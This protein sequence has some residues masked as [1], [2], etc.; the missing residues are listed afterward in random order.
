MNA[1]GARGFYAREH[2][3]LSVCQPH[4]ATRL[5]AQNGEK[6]RELDM[7]CVLN[8]TEDS[9]QVVPP[10]ESE[11]SFSCLAKISERTRRN[12]KVNRRGVIC[13]PNMFIYRKFWSNQFD[14]NSKL[15]CICGREST[16]CLLAAAKI[17]FFDTI[18]DQKPE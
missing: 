15:F 17:I 4:S 7:V 5:F 3:H 1:H 14:Q 13:G 18:P 10:T 16:V 6:P 11:L 2:S 12:I 8:N 9:T